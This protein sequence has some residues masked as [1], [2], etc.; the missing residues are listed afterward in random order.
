M[1]TALLR[2]TDKKELTADEAA[3][4]NETRAFCP[5][6]KTKVRLHRKGKNGLVAHFEHLSRKGPPCSLFYRG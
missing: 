3:L 1:E 5:E 4:R 2:I 6:C